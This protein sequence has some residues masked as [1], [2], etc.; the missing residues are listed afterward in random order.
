MW[1]CLSMQGGD[2]ESGNVLGQRWV[3][4]RE[5]ALDWRLWA[6]WGDLSTHLGLACWVARFG[7]KGC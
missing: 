2:L 6:D 4:H 3:T 1:K 7:T 5:T